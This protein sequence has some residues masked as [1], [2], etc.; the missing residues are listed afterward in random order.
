MFPR[1]ASKK[2]PL[3]GARLLGYSMAVTLEEKLG[4]VELLLLQGSE[5]DGA[6]S[7]QLDGPANGPGH[8][9]RVACSR[10]RRSSR[11][12]RSSRHHLIRTGPRIPAASP[13]RISS[14]SASLSTREA[15]AGACRP[16]SV[17]PD[18]RGTGSVLKFLPR[19]SL[20]LYRLR[21]T[22]GVQDRAF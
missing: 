17:C 21:G 8:G 14:A 19:A 6:G 16:G 3:P 5:L 13:R 22:S 18:A 4:L 7:F 10:P 15:T 2:T 9:P 20:D 12:A 1:A 11:S